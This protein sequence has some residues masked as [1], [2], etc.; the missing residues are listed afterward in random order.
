VN[1]L[2][3]R[4]SCPLKCV[5]VSSPANF[6]TILNN[7]GK[8][9]SEVYSR[10]KHFNLTVIFRSIS[11]SPAFTFG[12]QSFNGSGRNRLI[13]KAVCSVVLGSSNSV[14]TDQSA[15]IMKD[16]VAH[17]SRATF[18]LPPCLVIFGME[19]PRTMPTTEIFEPS[20]FVVSAS[21]MYGPA[22]KKIR[23]NTQEVI[24]LGHDSQDLTKIL[25]SYQVPDS[26]LVHAIVLQGS[27][28]PSCASFSWV[29]ALSSRWQRIFLVGQLVQS[30]K[31][32]PSAKAIQDDCLM[33]E[34][35]RCFVSAVYRF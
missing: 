4:I 30:L 7:L 27:F 25:Q 18:D 32:L 23:L 3:W 13:T 15:N 33:Q 11:I 20:L 35:P 9:A 1:L 10:G 16:S 5:R 19:I 2:R 24:R 28:Y 14:V 29:L 34:I 21:D 31:H 17:L 8:G 22:S 26:L 6:A 12:M